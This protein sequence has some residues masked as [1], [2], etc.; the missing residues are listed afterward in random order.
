MLV[1]FRVS[2]DIGRERR[3]CQRSRDVCNDGLVAAVRE[4]VVTPDN[5]SFYG[6]GL[7]MEVVACWDSQKGPKNT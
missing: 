7:I 2:C 6:V 3:C 5:C 1:S 4:E